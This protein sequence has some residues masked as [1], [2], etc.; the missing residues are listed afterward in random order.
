MRIA[1]HIES[2]TSLVPFWIDWE[3]E[4]RTNKIKPLA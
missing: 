2:K 1:D 3:S 4:D